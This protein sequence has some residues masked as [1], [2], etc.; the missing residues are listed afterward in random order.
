MIVG[1]GRCSWQPEVLRSRHGMGQKWPIDITGK[2]GL[3]PRTILF[4]WLAIAAIVGFLVWA[5]VTA[6]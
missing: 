5:A 4:G 1:T 3:G 6:G 2:S